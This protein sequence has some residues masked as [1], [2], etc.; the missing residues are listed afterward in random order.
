MTR[1]PANDNTPQ[2]L[3]QPQPRPAWFDALLLQHD[4]F[5]RARIHK[6]EKD[7]E[8]HEDIYQSTCL[9]ALEKWRTYRQDGN[10]A[11]WLHWAVFAS[12]HKRQKSAEYGPAL[13]AT[14]PSQEYAADLSRAVEECSDEI[15]LSAIGYSKAEI[16]RQ[17]G[18][19]GEAI[20]YRIKAAR[21]S[22]CGDAAN[23]NNK[24]AA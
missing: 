13:R 22:M 6:L 9:R 15:L 18:L 24:K 3:T 7:V 10:F 5:I 14:E 2:Q 16:G 1:T 17:E 23:D 4:P 12:T 11:G 8:K 21:A 19:T 20:Y